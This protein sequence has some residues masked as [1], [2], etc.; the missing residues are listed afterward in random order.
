ELDA[1]RVDGLD[2]P[3]FRS[4][5]F[6]DHVKLVIPRPGHQLPVLGEQQ[7]STFAWNREVF[8]QTRDYTVRRW[9]PEAATFDVDVV[10]HDS[11]LASDWAYACHIGDRIDFAG[12]K[13]SS[14]VVADAD[15]HF[16]AG[17]RSLARRSPRADEGASLHRSAHRRRPP[18]DRHGRRRGRHLAYSRI[19]SGRTQPPPT[20]I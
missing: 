3:P 7:E 12:P 11:G 4:I 6:D 19:R 8:S 18:G 14:E 17:D 16:L 20:R 1:A 2:R 5:G 9:D 13:M 10:R 15:W